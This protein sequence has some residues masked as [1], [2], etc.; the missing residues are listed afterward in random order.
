MQLTWFLY[1]N[2]QQ[3]QTVKNSAPCFFA[4]NDKQ[5]WITYHT[6]VT[7]LLQNQFNKG[8]AFRILSITWLWLFPNLILFSFD[9]FDKRIFGFAGIKSIVFF[10]L[11]HY[12]NYGTV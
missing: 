12:F 5:L 9:I 1:G 3:L 8:A 10:L 4:A 11:S 2:L 6:M 7:N